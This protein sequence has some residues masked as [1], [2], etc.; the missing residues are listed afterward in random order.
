MARIPGGHGVEPGRRTQLG[1]WSAAREAL[2]RA[3]A[4][5]VAYPLPHVNLARLALVDGDREQAERHLA[6]AKA[7]GYSGTVLD[8]L[9]HEAQSLLARIEGRAAP[10]GD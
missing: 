1:E 4:L 3:L 10:R 2:E 8:Q 7:L 5:D 6:T 9:L